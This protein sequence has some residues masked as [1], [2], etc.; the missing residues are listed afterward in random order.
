MTENMTNGASDF[1]FPDDERG[2][3]GMKLFLVALGVL[4]AASMVGYATIRSRLGDVV[5]IRLPAALWWSTLAMILSGVSI[6]RALVGAKQSRPTQLRGMLL[7]ALVLSL[8]F[9]TIQI[10]SA[11]QILREHAAY[12][13]QNVYL[14]GLAFTLIVLHALHVVGGL[15]PLTIVTLKS[16]RNPNQY[17]SYHSG[18]VHYVTM[19]WHF[20]EV[21]WIV[22]FG[23]LL[24]LG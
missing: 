12:R 17:H 13:A 19:Y 23:L 2:S 11:W 15:V 16:Q 8:A 18:P 21:V 5:S 3:L 10:P 6:S 4:F 22:M 1:T 24:L 14:Y 7:L 20:L 9:L